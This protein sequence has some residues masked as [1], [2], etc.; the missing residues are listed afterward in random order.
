MR[1]FVAGV[2]LAAVMGSTVPAARRAH[3]VRPLSAR[4]PGQARVQLPRRHLD[5]ER[6]RIESAAPDGAR[7]AR[8]VPASLA[9]RPLGRVHERSLRQRGR[10]PRFPSTGGEPKQL[11]FATGNDTVLNWAPD[12]K[13]ILITTSS[14]TSPWRSPLALVPIDGSLPRPLEMDG[15]VQGMIKQDG[16]S[17]AFNRMGGSYWRKGYRGNR[18]DDVWVQDLKTKT[19]HAPHR[20]RPQAVQGLHAGRL[21]DVGQRRA[22][23]LLVGAVGHLQHLPHRRRAAAQ[24]QQVTSHKDDGVQFPSMSPD[25]TTIAYENEFEIWTLKTGSRTPTRVT[26][27]LVVRSQH[28][29]RQLPAGRRTGSTASRSRRTATTRRSTSTARSSSSRPIPRSARSAR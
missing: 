1:L 8:H 27:D 26:I 12:G 29:P 7:R 28:E 5:R 21:P 19:H 23:L 22:D 4:Q 16:S 20:H 10:L 24:P 18:S 2:A 11:T 15:G 25:G 9:G 14:G 17:I 6:E 13:A 3:Q